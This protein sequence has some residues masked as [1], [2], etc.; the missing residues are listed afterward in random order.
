[1]KLIACLIVLSLISA[2]WSTGPVSPGASTVLED[3][4]VLEQ[5]H[6]GHSPIPLWWSRDMW[7]ERVF[8]A[9]RR[10]RRKRRRRRRQRRRLWQGWQEL[11]DGPA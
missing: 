8:P 4:I 9:C 6:R 10:R 5:L 7:M 3:H 1:M 11:M 2:F